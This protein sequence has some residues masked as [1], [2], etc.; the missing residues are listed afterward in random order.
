MRDDPK[1]IDFYFVPISVKN[2]IRCSESR[3]D[4][5]R[6]IK[7]K[8]SRIRILEQALGRAGIKTGDKV[9]NLF[10]GPQSYRHGDAGIPISIRVNAR[11]RKL[12]HRL[13]AAER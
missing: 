11:E 10:T 13:P 5:A 7:S 12:L 9:R 6:Q 4:S 1:H 3:Q 8:F 2:A